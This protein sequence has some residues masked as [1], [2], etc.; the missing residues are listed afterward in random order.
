MLFIFLCKIHST[1]VEL[2]RTLSDQRELKIMFICR[3]FCLGGESE[4]QPWNFCWRI[5][6]KRNMPDSVCTYKTAWG[7]PALYM[8]SHTATHS[9]TTMTSMTQQQKIRTSISMHSTYWGLHKVCTG[10]DKTFVLL[11]NIGTHFESS[12]Q[13]KF[14]NFLSLVLPKQ[15]FPILVNASQP[16]APKLGGSHYA[17]RNR[18][19]SSL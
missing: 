14:P 10:S 13:E 5:Q 7:S 11:P 18:V 9:W 3:C 17:P 4:L 1:I 12:H 8:W 2:Y 19:F 15:F 16:C 6:L